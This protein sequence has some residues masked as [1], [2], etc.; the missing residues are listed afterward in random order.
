[1]KITLRDLEPAFAE[2]VRQQIL[3]LNAEPARTIATAK[4]LA[5]YRAAG[6]TASDQ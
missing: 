3:W 2:R 6:N 1:M 4:E 5:D